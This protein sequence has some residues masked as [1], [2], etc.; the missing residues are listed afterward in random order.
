[1]DD[2]GDLVKLRMG[3]PLLRFHET[4]AR[5]WGY[6]ALAEKLRDGEM[7]LAEVREALRKALS[8]EG[9]V[10]EIVAALLAGG[11]LRLIPGL[12]IVGRGVFEQGSV[13]SSHTAKAQPLPEHLAGCKACAERFAAAVDDELRDAI[14]RAAE[15]HDAGKADPRFQAW[16]RGGNPVQPLKLLA[17]SEGTGQNGKAIERA[18]VLAGYPKGARH[19]LTSVALASGTECDLV[20]HLVASHHG[21]CRP[22][23][24]CIE[25]EDPVEVRYEGRTVRSDHGLES[26]GSGIAARF[27]RLTQQ[28]GWYGLAYLEAVLRLADHR[29]S[30][31]EQVKDERSVVHA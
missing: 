6:T 13:R 14:T 31:A 9:V 19:E 26:A 2:V 25:D 8:A 17:K 22:F 24:P 23:A 1:M 27:W 21:R 20:L 7:T 3:R 11:G 12:A 4:L 5:G 15:W 16:L 28:Y 18:R 29:Q 30:E 10:R